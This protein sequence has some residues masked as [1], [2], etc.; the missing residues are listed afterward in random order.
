MH[1]LDSRSLEHLSSMCPNIMRTMLEESDD[2]S[3]D[4]VSRKCGQGC[5]FVGGGRRTKEDVGLDR[6]HDEPE[7]DGRHNPPAVAREVQPHPTEQQETLNAESRYRVVP[8][9]QAN[10][11][12]V[13]VDRQIGTVDDEVEN[14]MREDSYRDHEQRCPSS[15]RRR[16][17]VSNSRR[18]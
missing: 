11:R 7:Q 9:A 13:I 3:E 6:Q 4:C 17:S 18:D 12:G 14:P 2:C 15:I 10:F 16:K 5:G 8:Q 1:Q